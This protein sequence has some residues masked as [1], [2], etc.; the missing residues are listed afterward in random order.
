MVLQNLGLTKLR[1]Y[2]FCDSSLYV[3]KGCIYNPSN[4]KNIWYLSISVIFEIISL[5]N[6]YKIPNLKLNVTVQGG[7]NKRLLSIN[8][9]FCSFS[10]VNF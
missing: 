7:Q 8:W 1:F 10:F 6:N 3:L 4:Y 5:K 9:N 2:I